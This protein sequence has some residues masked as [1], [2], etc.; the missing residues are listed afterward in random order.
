MFFTSGG[1]FGEVFSVTFV[2]DI[3][4]TIDR[5]ESYNDVP[6]IELDD[7]KLFMNEYDDKF[8]IEGLFPGVDKRDLIIDYKDDYIDVKVKLDN[9][10]NSFADNRFRRTFYVPD[11]DISRLN[12]SYKNDVLHFELPKLLLKESEDVEIIDVY[13]YENE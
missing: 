5:L 4:Q 8:V 7:I 11:V 6:M 9:Y 1:I 10:I 13:D 12:I 3:F 2:N